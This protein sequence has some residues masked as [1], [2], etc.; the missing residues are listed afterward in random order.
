M[1]H[2]NRFPDAINF[3]NAQVAS[4]SGNTPA[5]STTIPDEP[6]HHVHM[7]HT[8]CKEG[9]SCLRNIVS[10]ANLPGRN[11]F[12]RMGRAFIFGVRSVAPGLGLKNLILDCAELIRLGY[13]IPILRNAWGNACKD[14]NIFGIGTRALWDSKMTISK[15]SAGDMSGYH[16]NRGGSYN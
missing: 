3:I 12:R 9:R 4:I 5:D 1:L 15:A 13:T 10:F 2:D 7:A 8:C 16:G 14:N 11:T 6:H